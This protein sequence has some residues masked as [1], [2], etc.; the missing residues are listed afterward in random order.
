MDLG[1]ASLTCCGIGAGVDVHTDAR[2]AQFNQRTQMSTATKRTPTRTTTAPTAEQKVKAEI[3]SMLQINGHTPTAQGWVPRVVMMAYE[4][5]CATN[6]G[7]VTLAECLS[8]ASVIA[9]EGTAPPAG[10][11]ANR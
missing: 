11:A 1:F 6:P 2:R 7:N 9:R 3:E 8:V 5:R 10:P 4:R